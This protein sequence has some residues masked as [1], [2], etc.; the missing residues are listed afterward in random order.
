ME[1]KYDRQTF[2]L[3]LKYFYNSIQKL[4][5]LY[6]RICY[7]LCCK[8]DAR[9]CS[10]SEPYIYVN[11]TFY[12]WNTFLLKIQVRFIPE[13]IYHFFF[14]R[15]HVHTLSAEM[16]RNQ[17]EEKEED[18]ISSHLAKEDICLMEEAFPLITSPC[19]NSNRSRE[20]DLLP[21][22]DQDRNYDT[23]HYVKMIFLWALFIII[24]EK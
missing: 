17:E 16:K 3:S 24:F 7:V 12:T 1:L 21:T 14:S 18:A 11:R 2:Q 13:H 19:P 15:A 4:K 22:T 23:R 20:V 6:F 9:I 10:H 8:Y 5:C